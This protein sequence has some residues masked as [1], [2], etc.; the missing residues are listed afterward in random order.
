MFCIEAF[1]LHFSEYL[2]PDRPT[3]FDWDKEILEWGSKQMILNF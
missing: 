1:N 2:V 3:Q